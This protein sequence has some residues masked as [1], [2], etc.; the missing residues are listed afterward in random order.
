MC[1]GS[2]GCS[3]P[4]E[5]LFGANLEAGVTYR[6]VADAILWRVSRPGLVPSAKFIAHSLWL[7]TLLWE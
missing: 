5:E 4:R 1:A 7:L 2:P 3:V 6:T